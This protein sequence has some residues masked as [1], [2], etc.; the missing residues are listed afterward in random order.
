MASGMAIAGVVIDHYHPKNVSPYAGA[1][2][3]YS[4]FSVFMVPLLYMLT[5]QAKWNNTTTTTTAA[6]PQ[7]TSSTTDATTTTTGS[8]CSKLFTVAKKRDNIVFFMSVFVSG[9]LFSTYFAFYPLFMEDNMGK[10][11]KTQV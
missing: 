4:C 8:V 10:P 11:T 2:Y 7:T 9:F 5:K 1:F 6:T 3:V